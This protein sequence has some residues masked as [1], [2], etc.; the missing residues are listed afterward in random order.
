MMS[1]GLD[2]VSSSMMGSGKGVKM[3]HFSTSSTCPLYFAGNS[4]EI[5]EHKL[6]QVKDEERSSIF[7]EDAIN[8][9]EDDRIK[10]LA[11]FVEFKLMKMLIE[12]TQD[13]NKI[14]KILQI[15]FQ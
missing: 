13:I 15:L 11:P 14:L 1:D 9:W 2:G 3:E 10:A 7:A 12:S 6:N 5:L 8:L 4:Q